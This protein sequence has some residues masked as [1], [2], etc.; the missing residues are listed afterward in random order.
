MEIFESWTLGE[1][2]GYETSPFNVTENNGSVTYDLS[3]Y[4]NLPVTKVVQMMIILHISI[5]MAWRKVDDENYIANHEVI[6]PDASLIVSRRSALDLDLNLSGIALIDS[7]YLELPVGGKKNLI[8]NPYNVDLMISDLISP[9]LYRK[10][11]S[12]LLNGLLILSKIR[13]TT[14]WFLMTEY[15]VLIGMMEPI[16]I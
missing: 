8:N 12:L 10:T 3:I 2:F 13:L 16:G 6:S 11:I 5:K 1:L 7:T 15:G 9:E 14:S 4:L